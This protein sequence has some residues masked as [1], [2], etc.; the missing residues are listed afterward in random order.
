MRLFV[1]TSYKFTSTNTIH[2]KVS[3]PSNALPLIHEGIFPRDIVLASINIVI[4]GAALLTFFMMLIASD[5]QINTTAFE[6]TDAPKNMVVA[7]NVRI[8]YL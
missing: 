5:N 6:K 3:R 7:R 2:L 1:V 8:L 4:I